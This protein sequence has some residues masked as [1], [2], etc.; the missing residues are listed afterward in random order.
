MVTKCS[1]ERP[2]SIGTK[3]IKD[4][5]LILIDTSKELDF[6]ADIKYISF[7]KFSLTHQKL[8]VLFWKIGEN[9]P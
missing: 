9:T 4:G 3:P 7:V 6:Y 8:G 1:K 2:G 5:I